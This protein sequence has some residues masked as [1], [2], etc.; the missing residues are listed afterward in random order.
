[1]RRKRSFDEIFSL[2]RR[3]RGEL[4]RCIFLTEAA[5][6]SGPALFAVKVSRRIKKAVDRNL[7]KRSARE[8]FRGNKDLAIAGE[9]GAR[10][11]S[12]LFIYAG[13][14]EAKRSDAGAIRTDVLNL[15]KK[16]KKSYL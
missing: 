5:A 7:I 1:M 14:V 11:K 4:F 12:I 15:L 16:I 13:G 9:K 6:G 8:A 3:M 2:G 10:I